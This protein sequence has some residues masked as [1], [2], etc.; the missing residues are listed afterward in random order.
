MITPVSSPFAGRKSVISR[1]AER[2]QAGPA[3]GH[4]PAGWQ[5]PRH[6]VTLGMVR[7]P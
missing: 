7:G 2:G 5:R 3:G 1:L 4:G 6:A